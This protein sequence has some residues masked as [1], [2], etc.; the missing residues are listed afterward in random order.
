MATDLE[1]GDFTSKQIS[2]TM[3]AEKCDDATMNDF[4]SRCRKLA[5]YVVTEYNPSTKTH[6][7][8]SLKFTTG[9]AKKGRRTE[10]LND[11]LQASTY[12]ALNTDDKYLSPLICDQ[13]VKQF[14]EWTDTFKLR[15]VDYIVNLNDSRTV[16]QPTTQPS[17]Q[18]IQQTQNSQQF[19]TQSNQQFQNHNSQNSQ[20]FQPNSQNLNT[21]QNITSLSSQHL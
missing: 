5:R 19:Q 4:L 2:A 14:M 1:E 18:S 3:I 17:Q 13:I 15:A 11:F 16:V 12:I 9:N 20:N 8:I 21:N 7:R 6:E 10:Q